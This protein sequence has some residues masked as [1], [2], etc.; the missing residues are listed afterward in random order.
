MS[1]GNAYFCFFRVCF[2]QR[3]R[4]KVAAQ[5]SAPPVAFHTRQ[6]EAR[7]EDAVPEEER[8]LPAADSSVNRDD[9]DE[10]DD[11]E[12]NWEFPNEKNP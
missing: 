1:F 12:E 11:E 10:D 4:R 8:P 5:R 6:N 9:A 2:V 7:I 3:K